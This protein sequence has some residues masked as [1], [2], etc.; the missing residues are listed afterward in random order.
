MSKKSILTLI[1]FLF[2]TVLHA[3]QWYVIIAKSCSITNQRI[4]IKNIYLKK[5]HFLGKC[6]L[7]PLN[8][9][10][11]HPIRQHFT[12]KVLNVSQ[13]SWTRYYNEMHFKGIDPPHIV[14][15]TQSMLKYLE[16][17]HGA[18]GYLPHS[19]MNPKTLKKFTIL[20]KFKDD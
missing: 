13:K 19:A 8:I 9:S 10:S 11:K 1:F 14:S 18:I 20:L 3:E 15:S 4:S 12:K 17:I 5:Q 2:T 7:N 6:S 16:N